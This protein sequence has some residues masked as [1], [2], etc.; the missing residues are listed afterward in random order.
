MPSDLSLI[1]FKMEVKQYLPDGTFIVE[2]TPDD[3]ECYPIEHAVVIPLD[4]NPPPSASDILAIIAGASPQHYWSQLKSAI[5]FDHSLR[6]GL[7]GEVR[8]NADQLVNT[9][10][11]LDAE[12]AQ[13]NSGLSPQDL[14]ILS[15]TLMIQQ[16]LSE[17]IGATV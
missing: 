17:M 1:P 6:E 9:Q 13:I 8:E 4:T 2:Y 16:I 11:A 5:T 7:V 10:S 14:Q 15:T 3:P 12:L